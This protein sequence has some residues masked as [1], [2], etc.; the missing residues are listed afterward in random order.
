MAKSKNHTNKNQSYKAH[1][2][3]I[4][5]PKRS[6][7]LPTCGM[8]EKARAELRAEE[9]EKNPVAKSKNLSFEERYRIGNE[10]PIILRRRMIQKAGIAR[11]ARNGIYLN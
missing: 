2:R 5:K 1:R 11:M 8:S 10:N 4:K 3:G 7:M 9:E 6:E